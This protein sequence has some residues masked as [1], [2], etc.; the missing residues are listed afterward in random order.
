MPNLLNLRRCHVQKDKIFKCYSA[1][2]RKKLETNGCKYE[3]PAIDI[4]NGKTFWLFL[5]DEKVNE[6]LK[7]WKESKAL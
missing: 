3:F 6:V 1:N 2:L 5:K 7:L 4:V